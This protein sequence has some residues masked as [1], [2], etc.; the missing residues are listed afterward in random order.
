MK[1]FSKKLM[2][3]SEEYADAQGEEKVK[4][5]DGQSPNSTINLQ[6]F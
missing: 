2:L 6:S 5:Q 4:I 1:G 3:Q